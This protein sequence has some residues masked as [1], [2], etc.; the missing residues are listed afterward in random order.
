MSG[1]G[2]VRWV[3]QFRAHFRH[4]TL[5]DDK[6]CFDYEKLGVGG[7]DLT[8]NFALSRRASSIASWKSSS[9]SLRLAAL[10]ESLLDPQLAACP[11]QVR[12]EDQFIGIGLQ[13]LMYGG[14]GVIDPTRQS[15]V[16]PS[17]PRNALRPR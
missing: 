3:S 13:R 11:K 16:S 12:A 2:P 8:D 17:K 6:V 5:V 14:K 10:S 4:P 9:A 7:S 1:E 15:C